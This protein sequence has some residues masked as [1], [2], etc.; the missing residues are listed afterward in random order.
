MRRWIGVVLTCFCWGTWFFSSEAAP[1]FKA[2][3]YTE[4]ELKVLQTQPER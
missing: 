2:D 3:Q 4:L 1:P